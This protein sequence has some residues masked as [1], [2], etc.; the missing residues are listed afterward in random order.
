MLGRRL[1]QAS[2]AALS[3]NSTENRPRTAYEAAKSRLEQLFPPTQSFP[4]PSQTQEVPHH[5][6]LGSISV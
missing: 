6:S 1:Y 5:L 4:Q 3:Q 2:S